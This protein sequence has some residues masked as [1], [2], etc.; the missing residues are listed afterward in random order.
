MEEAWAMRQISYVNPSRYQGSCPNILLRCLDPRFHAALDGVLPQ[1]LL[2]MS[3][4]GAFAC[5]ALP[6]GAKAI[7]DPESRPVVFRALDLAIATLKADRLIIANHRDCLACGG[8]TQHATPQ[9]EAE[10]HAVQLQQAREAMLEVYPRLQ[11]VLVF[12]DWES[13]REVE[14]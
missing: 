12:Q 9:E 11:V 6:G 10:F 5:M 7:L 4:S 2:E 13:I 3:G 8:S 14:D 1:W